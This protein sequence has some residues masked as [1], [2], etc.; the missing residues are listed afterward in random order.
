MK[1]IYLA[2]K[3]L[4]RFKS[5]HSQKSSELV[6][7]VRQYLNAQISRS[8]AYWAKR[9]AIKMIHDPIVGQYNKLWEC[10]K[11]IRRIKEDSMVKMLVNMQQPTG[12][13]I[14][15][16]FYIYFTA[17][18]QG[19]LDGCKPIIALDTCYLK[20]PCLRWLIAI[21]GKMMVRIQLHGVLL[22]LNPKDARISFWSFFSLILT[23]IGRE[24]RHL[25]LTSK[26]HHYNLYICIG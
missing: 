22:K 25:Y 2:N 5:Q 4:E 15:K 14:F 1:S 23:C 6:M 13:A 12:E 9:K 18:K 20:G 21:V 24:A 11:E 17:C 3:Y 10:A 19:F 26:R 16:R 7:Q 8:Q